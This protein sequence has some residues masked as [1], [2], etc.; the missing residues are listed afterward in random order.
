MMDPSFLNSGG[1]SLRQK[2]YDELRQR[3]RQGA[4]PDG[5]KLVDVAIAKS[6]G[7]SRMPVREALLQLAAE[8]HVQSTTRGFEVRVPDAAAIAEIFEARRLIE[9]QVAANAARV[10]T[11][12]QLTRMN[13]LVEIS[14]EAV[15]KGDHLTLG[16]AN[17][18]FRAIWV[19]ASPNRRL[20]QMLQHFTD[21]VEIVRKSTLVHPH[22][23]RVVLAGMRDL[24]RAFMR[25]DT[26][27][28]AQR[29]YLF[30]ADAESS[31]RQL[32]HVLAE[33]NEAAAAA[34]QD[35][36][37]S[38]ATEGGIAEALPSRADAAPA[39]NGPAPETA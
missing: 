21:Q 9:P 35:P 13:V 19:A 31:Y 5:T 7:I 14:A 12:A 39:A 22:T 1:D 10:L 16:H 11:Q 27:A 6:L 4:F 33:L 26:L 37:L 28:V 34:S 24:I 38:D 17:A 3:I 32:P 30:T 8:G 2:V 18:E 36:L 29:M 25:R 23:Q 15:A 20:A